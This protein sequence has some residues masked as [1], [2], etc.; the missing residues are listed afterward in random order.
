MRFTPWIDSVRQRLALPRPQRRRRRRLAARSERLEDRTLLTASTLW[1]PGSGLLS[2]TAT[3][4]ESITV[5][6]NPMS[7]VEV[8]IDGVVDTSLPVIPAGTVQQIQVQGGDGDNAIDLSNVGQALFSYTDLGGDGVQIVV[9]GGDGHD[10]ITGSLDLDDTLEGGDG[11]DILN[12]NLGDNSLDGGDG[13]DSLTGGSG[14]DYLDGEDGRDTIEAGAGDDS[15][16]GGNGQDSLSGGVGADSLTGGHGQDTLDGG[17]ED[18][19][20]D[21]GDG[22]DLLT[23]DDGNDKLMGGIDDDTLRGG[24]D[25]DTLL[26][27]AGNDSLV[28]E[29]GDDSLVGGAE[30]D[31]LLGGDGDDRLNGQK[32]NDL[33]EGGDGDDKMLAGHGSDVLRGGDGDDTIRGQGGN[34]TLT[35]SA[36][37][38]YLDGGTGRDLLDTRASYLSINDVQLDVEGN[39]GNNTVLTFT[40]TIVGAFDSAFTVDYATSDDTATAGSDYQSASGQLTFSPGDV[41]Q[42]LDVTVLGDTVSESAE[43]FSVTLSN[44][45]N[46]VL[47]DAVGQGTII[48]DDQIAGANF[49][50]HAWSGGTPPDPT[51]A[52]GPN[53]LVAMV[54][55]DIGI[56]EKDGT[57]T[58]TASLS[59]FFDTVD[60]DFGSFDPWATYD[61]YSDRYLVVAEEV[62]FG[63]VNADG[64]GGQTR[65]GYGA[66]E[67]Y[68]LI[69]LSTSDTP[70]DLDIGGGD[71]DWDLFAISATRDFG[72]GLAWIDYPRITADADSIYITGNYFLFGD[73]S[74]QGTLVTRLDKTTMLSGTLGS[75]NDVVAN[76]FTLQPALGV[77]RAAADPQLFVSAGNNAI[78]VWEMDDSN[79]LTN[80][81]S[82]SSPYVGPNFGV[83]QQGTTATLSTV[84]PRL[85]NAVWRNN[86]LWTTHTVDVGGTATARWYEITTTG[87]SYSLRQTGNISPASGAHT[88]MP[89]I[90]VDVDGNMGIT[91]T[92][93][94]STQFPTMMYAGRQASDPLG[95]TRAGTAVKSGTFYDGGGG[96]GAV[97]RWGDYAG[98]AIDP[99]DSK[100]F[101]AFHEYAETNTAWGTH[102]ASFRLAPDTPPPPPPPP[103]GG[104]TISGS[105]TLLGGNGYDTLLGGLTDDYLV[106]G[107]AGDSIDGGE[108]N[109]TILGESGRDTINGGGGSD[110][111]HGQAGNDQIDGGAGDDVLIWNIT[112]ANDTVSGGGGFDRL[113]LIGEDTA[114]NFSVS[115]TSGGSARMQITDGTHKVTLGTA[116]E[117]VELTTGDGDDTVTVGDQRGVD[118]SLLIVRGEDGNDT[119][120]AE[121]AD[122]DSVRLVLDGGDGIDQLTGSQGGDTL[123]GGLGND[124]LMA[125]EGDDQVEAGEGD[126]TLHGEDGDDTLFGDDGDDTIRGNSGD[127]SLVGGDGDDSLSAGDDQDTLEGGMGDDFLNGQTGNDFLVGQNGADTLI[128]GSGDDVLDGG[129]NDDRLLGNDGDD[130]LRGDDGDDQLYGQDGNDI[131]NGGDGNDTLEGSKGADGIHGGDGD[132]RINAGSGNDTVVGGDGNDTMFGGSGGDIVLG[133]DGN[134]QIL[135]QGSTVDTLAGGEGS[136]QLN[137]GSASE[138][139]ETFVLSSTIMAML[140]AL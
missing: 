93:S 2:V 7:E 40:V 117:V 6:T 63:F 128:G 75:R 109:D 58:E 1:I 87:S 111:I 98:I 123:Y 115:K 102:W 70:D 55:F 46:V 110:E 34:D 104:V 139:D 138:I 82:L 114:D 32:H 50:G 76:A 60:H 91:Y 31:T 112:D 5:G 126:D 61:Q 125:G 84:S 130:R 120:T 137:D 23:G 113:L 19:T 15:L 29:D 124:V 97:N 12:G 131:L 24:N 18:D 101:W 65:A 90:A 107:V 48:D 79:V 86:S 85:M 116:V 35:D 59:S 72:N 64:S 136:D 42:T 127:D 54:N 100:T 36:G 37:D 99:S 140:D 51:A 108:G 89:G 96:S 92:Q 47:F 122:I 27:Q 21:G 83:P 14:D 119:L 20:L 88:F 44:S 71:N 49:P 30:R 52:A 68:L 78:N 17:S 95:T 74:Y 134:D 33:L 67:A 53:N 69:G 8:E 132:D 45:G 22:A 73:H 80:V 26:G 13:N 94:S 39:T 43:A 106:G 103:P 28:G 57:A 105:D 38:D 11:D 121:N 9:N 129:L 25:D 41:Q 77:G 135:G 66:D 62:E 3:S 4:G 118:G 56:W 16:V 10:T 81:A 133:G